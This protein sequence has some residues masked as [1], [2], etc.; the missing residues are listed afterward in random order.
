LP[1]PA[2]ELLN[3]V[4]EVK[5]SLTIGCEPMLFQQAHHLP[6]LASFPRR[7]LGKCSLDVKWYVSIPGLLS[8]LSSLSSF[9]PQLLLLLLS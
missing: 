2:Q 7:V 4:F 1:F 3:A 9:V 8:S 5:G 6:D